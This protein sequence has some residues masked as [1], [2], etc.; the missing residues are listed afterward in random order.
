LKATLNT[1]VSTRRGREGI[2]TVLTSR[3]TEGKRKENEH[4]DVSSCEGK[5][6]KEAVRNDVRQTA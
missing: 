6:R 5:G 2:R 1:E 4:G 3:N